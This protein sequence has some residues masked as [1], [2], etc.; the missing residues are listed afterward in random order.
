VAGRGGTWPS[1]G[2][3]GR[4]VRSRMSVGLLETASDSSEWIPI[5]DDGATLPD[6]FSLLIIVRHSERPSALQ[7]KGQAV[8]GGATS[9]KCRGGK[10]AG[11]RVERG[12]GEFR[13]DPR[14]PSPRREGE[15]LPTAP[16]HYTFALTF[17]LLLRATFSRYLYMPRRAHAR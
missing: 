10:V 2:S 13:A 9:Y 17:L 15:R 4:S 7:G 3:S 1:S 8:G 11:R 12:S 16:R 14:T 6:Q 5:E